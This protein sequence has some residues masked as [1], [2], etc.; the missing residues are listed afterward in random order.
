MQSVALHGA[1]ADGFKQSSIVEVTR[2]EPIRH[3]SLAFLPPGIAMGANRAKIIVVDI[4]DRR[5]GMQQRC[6]RL[7]E[8][9]CR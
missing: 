5:E 2:M 8:C 4:R 9:H 6:T 1:T 7:V 3:I